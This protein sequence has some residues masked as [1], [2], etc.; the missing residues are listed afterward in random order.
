MRFGVHSTDD[1]SPKTSRYRPMKSINKVCIFGN[2]VAD[3]LCNNIIRGGAELQ[4]ALLAKALA[5]KDIRVVVVDLMAERD[6][7]PRSNLS[8]KGFPNWNRGIR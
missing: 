1:I 3:I 6:I 4:M 2:H 8:I 7:Q 5:A